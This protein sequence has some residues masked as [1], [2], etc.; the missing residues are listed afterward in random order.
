MG[1]GM[2]DHDILV[3]GPQVE[4]EFGVTSMTIWRWDR[5]SKLGF[6]PAIKINGRSYRSRLMLEAFKAK[7]LAEAM[8]T[9]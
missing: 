8:K 7:L 9:R 4:R 6:P 1:D 5:D 2:D 3:P